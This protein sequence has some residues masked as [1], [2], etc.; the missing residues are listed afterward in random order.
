MRLFAAVVVVTAGGLT[1]CTEDAPPLPPALQGGTIEAPGCGYLVTSREGA[2]APLLAD[3][4]LGLDPTVRQVHLGLAADPRS[5]M[6]VMWRTADDDT[7]AGVVRHGV[8]GLTAETRAITYMYQSGIGGLG[9]PVRVHEAHLCGLTAGTE[10]QYQIVSDELHV[11]PLYTFRTAPDI[12]T[13]PDAEVII[14]NVG[15]SR[16]GFAVWAMLVEQLRTRTPDLVLFSGDAVTIG[17]FQD[18]WDEFFTAGEP[19]LSQVPIL[20]AHGNHEIHAINFYAQ[21]AMPGEE[22]NFSLD[23]GHAHI[24]VLDTSPPELGDLTSSI[25][26]FLRDDLA[27][28]SSARWKLVNH[29]YGVYSASNHGSD[30]TLQAAWAPLYDRHHVDLVLTGHDH[31]YE[32]TFPM[33]NL[34]VVPTPAEGTIY[35][36]SG[37]AGASLYASG[38]EAWT[39]FST[40][41][42]S[43]LTLRIRN[44]MLQLDA[45]DPTGAPI[46]TFTI[47]KP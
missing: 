38:T 36:V 10:Y 37:G 39:A 32:R 42:H 4:H 6:V 27:A 3:D 7:R 45:F 47:T 2:E 22:T 29:H 1:A 44:T 21:L 23:Y 18:E 25:Q 9:T 8:G 12:T 30:P 46:D 40:S 33:N 26:D 35:I 20:S 28:S 5:N 17:P 24:T 31:N 15:D 19:L 11:S 41:V 16:D 14:A 34:K 13:D 43:A